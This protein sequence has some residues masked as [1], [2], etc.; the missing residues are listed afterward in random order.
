MQPV[1]IY[2]VF[3]RGNINNI[4]V[5]EHGFIGGTRVDSKALSTAI[6]ENFAFSISPFPAVK[7]DDPCTLLSKE[8]VSKIV[9]RH[10]RYVI[11]GF[12]KS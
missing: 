10:L 6:S 7:L 8:M 11:N 3:I 5:Y 2:F 4:R 12:S 9:E 1:F